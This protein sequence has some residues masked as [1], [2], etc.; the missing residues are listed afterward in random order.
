[1][2]RREILRY[3]AYV[4]GAAVSAPLAATILSGCKTDGSSVTEKALSFFS[5]DDM[6]LVKKVI[7]TIIPATDSPSATDVGV[8]SMID[9]MVGKVYSPEDQKSY[10]ESISTLLSHLS[11]SDDIQS[12][13]AAL[14]DAS[15]SL[16][17]KTRGAYHQLKEQTIAYYL[18][19][20]EIGTKY[21]NY[22]PVPGEYQ[23]CISVQETG[24]KKW[25]I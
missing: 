13:V 20:E 1:M 11:A 19:S 10:G 24:G 15:T 22:L 4:T 5:S 21:L 6:G 18:S 23:A 2:N 17:E 8:H 16:P 14:E 9:H 25:A 12:A 7:D 3:T